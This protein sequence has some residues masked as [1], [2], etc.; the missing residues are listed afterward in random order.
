MRNFKQSIHWI[1]SCN[2]LGLLA[3]NAVISFL[4]KFSS[5]ITNALELCDNSD[6]LASIQVVIGYLSLE[7]ETCNLR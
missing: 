7:G 1:R 5:V 6:T 2:G 3:K 4:F